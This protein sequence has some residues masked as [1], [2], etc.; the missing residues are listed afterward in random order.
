MQI[1][2]PAGQFRHSLWKEE[3]ST[4][5]MSSHPV[6]RDFGK[7]SED[8]RS[9]ASFRAK[10]LVSINIALVQRSKG[11]IERNAKEPCETESRDQFQDMTNQIG[12]LGFSGIVALFFVQGL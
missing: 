12:D 11:C 9:K 6:H 1:Q 4:L 7:L 8:G 3:H 10:G 2:I 5:F